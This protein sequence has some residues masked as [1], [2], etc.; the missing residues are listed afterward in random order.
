MH[1]WL[2]LGWMAKEREEKPIAM[3]YLIDLPIASVRYR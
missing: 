2:N 3:K 1:L